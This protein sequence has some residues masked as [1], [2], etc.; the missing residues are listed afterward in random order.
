[1]GH[2]LHGGMLGGICKTHIAAVGVA[3]GG[4]GVGEGPNGPGFADAGAF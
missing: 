3:R 2:L 1:M 4:G